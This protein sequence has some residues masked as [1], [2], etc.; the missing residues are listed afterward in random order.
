MS[1]VYLQQNSTEDEQFEI[2]KKKKL[3]SPLY[4]IFLI[5]IYTHLFDFTFPP[6]N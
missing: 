4:L 5:F 2:M 6:S 1:F 3:S